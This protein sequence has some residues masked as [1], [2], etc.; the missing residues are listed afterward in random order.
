VVVTGGTACSDSTAGTP[1]ASSTPNTAT[2]RPSTTGSSTSTKTSESADNKLQGVDPCDLLTASAAA[3]L[4]VTG[5]PETEDTA[6]DPSRLCNWRVRKDTIADSYTLGVVVFEKL[7][8]KDVIAEGA[9]TPLTI[10]SHQAGQS[11]HGQ[12][13]TCS[14][15]LAVTERSRVDVLASGRDGS[16]LCGPVL[17]AAKLVEPELPK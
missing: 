15:T 13:G 6:D 9:I 17:E 14:V 2:E 10:G 11:L 12:G 8:L 7:G 4:G 3:T 5:Q 1:T 16:K